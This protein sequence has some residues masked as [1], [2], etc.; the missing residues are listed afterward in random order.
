MSVGVLDPDGPALNALNAIGS[1]AELEYVARHALNREVLMDGSD[2]V[3]LG[4]KNDPVVGGI[5]DG[6]AGCQRGRARAAPALQDVMDSVAV[7]ERA[8]AAS[9]R[10]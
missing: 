8:I 9:A 2:H 6:A 10:R 4:L 5:R 7:N 1:V 3:V